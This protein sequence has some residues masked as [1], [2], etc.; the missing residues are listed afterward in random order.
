MARDQFQTM[1]EA[2]EWLKVSEATIRSWVKDSKGWRITD[3]KLGISFPAER[4]M[5]EW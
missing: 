1:N 2:A 5:R 3:N 4:R